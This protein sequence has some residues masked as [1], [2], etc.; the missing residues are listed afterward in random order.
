[1]PI[2]FIFTV[3]TGMKAYACISILF[4]SLW[5]RSSGKSEVHKISEWVS[6]A[7]CNVYGKYVYIMST[8]V[9]NKKFTSMAD[10]FHCTKWIAPSYYV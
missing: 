4:Y 1:M 10:V 2:Y 7:M 6:L 8:C 5:N 9:C 3:G